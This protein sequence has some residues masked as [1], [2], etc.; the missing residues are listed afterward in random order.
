MYITDELQEAL[1]VAQAA[2]EGRFWAVKKARVVT[3]PALVTI[4]IVTAKPLGSKDGSILG[5]M[6][7]ELREKFPS[8][9]DVLFQLVPEGKEGVR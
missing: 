5:Y 2:I 7:G 6:I 4:R 9:D 3:S 1:D 8:L